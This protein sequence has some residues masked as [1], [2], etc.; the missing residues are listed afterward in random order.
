MKKI[1]GMVGSCSGC[2]LYI[3]RFGKHH[4]PLQ[5]S[6]L[7]L[8]ETTERQRQTATERD[9]VLFYRGRYGCRLFYGM[10]RFF[11]S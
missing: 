3:A 2:I 6:K 9:T 1:V 5:N 8:G 10:S 11:H 7:L 4:V